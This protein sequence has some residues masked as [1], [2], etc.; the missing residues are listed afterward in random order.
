MRLGAFALVL[1]CASHVKNHKGKKESR[2]VSPQVLNM[3]M[4]MLLFV[5]IAATNTAIHGKCMMGNMNALNAKKL[6]NW[7]ATIP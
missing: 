1:S 5:R 7:S 6:L 3:T 2:S 4:K